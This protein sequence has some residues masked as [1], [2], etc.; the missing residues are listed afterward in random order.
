MF[1]ISLLLEGQPSDKRDT[2][3]PLPFHFTLRKPDRLL[4]YTC[5]KKGT[6]DGKDS[7]K[8]KLQ[9]FCILLL[10]C[11]FFEMKCL[12]M[13]V[14]WTF[15][16]ES[17]AWKIYAAVGN[18]FFQFVAI[19]YPHAIN[20]LHLFSSIVPASEKGESLL[21]HIF[22]FASVF[23]HLS[24]FFLFPLCLSFWVF[25]LFMLLYTLQFFNVT[26]WY[27]SNSCLSIFSLLFL[28]QLTRCH[29]CN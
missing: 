17:M 4:P 19:F 20:G 2:S 6:A 16:P 14:I 5:M 23:R 27:C 9:I 3:L 12:K 29:L 7:A 25:S 24:T 13:T 10:K 15:F 8:L 1:F 26:L 22:L 28:I 11:F 18:F 21:E